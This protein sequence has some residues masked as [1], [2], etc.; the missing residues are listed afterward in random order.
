MLPDGTTEQSTENIRVTD[1]SY[2]KQRRYRKQQRH[3]KTANRDAAA[4]LTPAALPKQPHSGAH[5]QQCHPSSVNPA[6]STQRGN[7]TGGAT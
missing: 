4:R 5:H 1:W 7:K 6:V 2:R 3:H